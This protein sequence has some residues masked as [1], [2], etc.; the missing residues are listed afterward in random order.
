M[1]VGNVAAA[2]GMQKEYIDP[3][4]Q[5][6]IASYSRLYKHIKVNTKIK[7]VSNRP[8]KIPLQVQMGGK[9]SVGNFDGAALGRG[10]GP[11][12]SNMSVSCVSYVQAS[13]W[14]SQAE[15]TTDSNEKSVEDY[16]ALLQSQQMQTMAGFLDALTQ[17]NGSNTLDTVVSVSGS[18]LTVSNPNMFMSNQDVDFWT[19]YL[20]QGGSY[21]GTG[22]ILSLDPI[23][24]AVVLTAAPPVGVGAGT[25]VLVRNS[26]GVSNSGFLGLRAW[27]MAGNTGLY[28]NIQKSAYPGL[29]NIA[30][31][32]APGAL[33]P[34]VV[35]GVRNLIAQHMGLENEESANL[36]LHG[37]LD[38]I[39]AWENNAIQV[40]TNEYNMI[41]GDQNPDF[42]KKRRPDTIGGMP[43]IINERAKPGYLD[44]LPLEH[45]FQ[46][47]SK[48]LS[49]YDVKGQVVFPAYG[50]DGSVAT[51]YLMYMVIM[52]QMVSVQPG[53]NGYVSGFN[54]PRYLLWH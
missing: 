45:Y 38:A 31:I 52:W 26:S 54:A 14:T 15:W 36:V 39:T 44:F 53:L 16:A 10:S 42:L 1:P 34:A 22:T 18:T 3:K 19:N 8:A 50:S 11:Q 29:F 25:L 23:N 37:N 28:G 24:M 49:L 33:T 27:N 9:V 40:Q 47:T 41:R 35:R 30:N 4:V 6:L 12:L 5:Q 20:D 2:V 21:L 48:P 43:T 46:I 13:E 51:A 17:T 7:P 32:N